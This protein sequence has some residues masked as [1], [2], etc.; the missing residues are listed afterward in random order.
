MFTQ[1]QTM[2]IQP[3]NA[4]ANHRRHRRAGIC[5]GLVLCLMVLF[6][7][8]P[9]LAATAKL[10]FSLHKQGSSPAAPTLL[11]IGGIQGDEPGGF[12]AA[13]L[14]VTDYQ[15][16]YGNVWVVPNLNFESIVHRSRG[17][18]GDMNRKFLGLDTDDPEYETVQKIKD[19]I[20]NKQVDIVLNLHDGSGYYRPRHHDSLRGPHRWGQSLIIDQAELPNAR[21]GN[22]YDTGERVIRRVNQRLLDPEHRYH[23]KNTRTREGDREMEKTLTYFAV[24][25]NR[26]AFGVEASK[27]MN[28]EFRAFYHL[29][30]IE[31]FMQEMGIEYRRDFSLEPAH[32]KQAI[33]KELYLT[34]FNKRLFLDITNARNWLRYI[35][36]TPK[37]PMQVEASNPLLAVVG[38]GRHFKVRY[39]NRGVAN[40]HPEFV[41]F[42]DSLKYIPVLVDDRY[43]LVRPGEK[44]R[45]RNNFMVIPRAEYRVNIIGF[46]HDGVDDEAGV[47]VSRENFMPR[48][49]IDREARKFRIEV[50]QGDKFSGMILADFSQQPSAGSVADLAY[51]PR[52]AE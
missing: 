16:D 40:L 18:H 51:Y 39:G 28:T 12:N 14:L 13:S 15:I 50:Y 42:D 20:L 27:S 1:R 24:R 45:V 29:N 38:S 4:A 46:V 49:S 19:I 23:L 25:H 9:L 41:E 48:F 47:F 35:P 52:H 8:E 5:S 32:V 7:L 10:D 34:M 21:Y 31:A 17:V 30:V 43:Q 37:Q 11:I 33:E 2:T 3:D 44:I 26:A 6:P 36:M 22:L